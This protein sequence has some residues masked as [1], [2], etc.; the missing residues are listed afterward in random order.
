MADPELR[1]KFAKAWGVN[2]LEKP[3]MT[4][5]EM[6]PAALSGRHQG[7]FYICAENPMVSDPDITHVRKALAN[8]EF[9]VVQDIFLTETA[10]L[11]DVVL[12][13]T[14]FAEKDGTFTNTERRI[15]RVRQAISP[16]GESH[17]T[18]RSFAIWPG[19]WAMGWS[20][21]IQRPSWTSRLPHP[22]LR[23]HR[24]PPHR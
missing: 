8:L 3:G 13:G 16:R 7:P 1:A 15:Q 23:R 4:I 10:E 22:Q 12:P 24:L 5:T 2:L 19:A 18:G 6:I 17:L 21:E 11:V 14:T 20:I 9:L